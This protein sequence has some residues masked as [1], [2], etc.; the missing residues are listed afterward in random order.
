MNTLLGKD[1]MGK[2]ISDYYHNQLKGKLETETNISEL[3][4]FPIEYLFRDFGEM[5]DL[6]QNALMRAKGRVLDVGCG[7]GSHSLY[8][9]DVKHLDVTALDKSPLAIE[10][11]KAR[12][13]KNAICT[14]L[15]FLE[16]TPFDTIL[17]LMN[18]TGIFQNLDKI[19]EYLQKLHTLLVENGEI[20]ID[21]N[22]IA[23]MYDRDEDGGILIPANGRYY[24]EVEF[25]THY[26]HEI[27]V[28]PWLYLDFNT[29]HHAARANGFLS[30]IVI[31]DGPAYLAKL[32]KI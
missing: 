4:D 11:A 29:L 17:L 13:V 12:G 10:I 18:G 6:E 23:Y 31:E 26:N 15:L 25:I 28:F 5:N 14:D 24:G 16:E 30:E 7:A 1:L 21:S 8:L 20:L 3:D 27:E 32:T 2:A 19:D 22:D 9:Q